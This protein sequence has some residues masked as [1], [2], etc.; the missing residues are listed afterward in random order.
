MATSK[1][2]VAKNTKA[3]KKTIVRTTANEK[4][5]YKEDAMPSQRGPA[6]AP[7]TPRQRSLQD[8]ALKESKKLNK[9]T[10]PTTMTSKKFMKGD[11]TLNKR[12]NQS[13]VARGGKPEKT[14]TKKKP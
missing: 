6:S 8:T 9:P 2:A 11:K 12:V 13:I 14:Y 4:M 10:G 3:V 7:L 1:K 5:A